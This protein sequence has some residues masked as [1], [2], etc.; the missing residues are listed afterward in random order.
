MKKFVYSLLF[1]VMA[2][3]S[4][5]SFVSCGSDDDDDPVKEEYLMYKFWLSNDALE[6][7]DVVA[8]GINISFTTPATYGDISGKEATIELVGAATK[9]TS[10]TITLNPKS[11]WKEILASKD[12]ATIAFGSG[13]G[14]VKGTAINIGTSITSGSASKEKSGENYEAAVEHLLTTVK[15][16]SK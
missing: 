7:A 10:F 9:T 5:V 15:L 13:H 2:I 1:V 11:N 6:L 16:H 4:V 3:V 12:K 8:S 14:D